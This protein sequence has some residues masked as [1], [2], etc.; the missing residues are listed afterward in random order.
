[1]AVRNPELRFKM[2]QI[3]QY[4]PWSSLLLVEDDP[5]TRKNYCSVILKNFPGIELYTAENGKIG[6][7]LY[8]E[9]TPQIVVTDVNLPVI[10]GIQMA[11]EIKSSYPETV[12][13]AI[14]GHNDARHL[15]SAIEIGINNYLIKPVDF[16]KFLSLIGKC[17][18]ESNL[19]RLLKEQESEIRRLSSFPKLSPD[20]ILELDADGKVVFSNQAAE[21]IP[22]QVECCGVSN[23]FMPENLPEILRM[24]QEKNAGQSTTEIEINGRI[25]HECIHIVPEFNSTRIYATDITECKKTEKELQESEKRYHSLFENM[26]NGFAYCKM[27]FDE[28]GRPVDFVYLEVNSA[29]GRLFGLENVVGKKVTEVFPGIT[30]SHP[31]LIEIYG[32]VALTGR[33]EKF[34]FDFKQIGAWLSIS[35]YSTEKGYFVAVFDDITERKRTE[36]EIRCR[37]NRYRELSMTD[38]LTKL[39]NSR[40]FFNRLNYEV[41]RAKRYRQPLSLVLLDIDNFKGYNDTYGHFEGDKVIRVL[42]EVI[43]KNL[44]HIDMA[45][46][47]GG[48]EFTVLLPETASNNAFIV[49]ERIRENFAKTELCPV[50]ESKV[51]MT[52]SIGVGQYIPDEQ[53]PT[54]LKR[55]DEG[56]YRAKELGKNQAYKT[57]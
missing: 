38:S 17:I 33:P 28:N 55:V 21:K 12:I 52:I 9:H 16:E 48:E 3:I 43:R 14:S 50:P 32:R 40:H 22:G 57:N 35:V 19:K 45:F 24:M 47:Y 6:L 37:E 27:L 25:Y 29:F 26:L 18:N 54:F 56:M 41:D 23:P 4:N 51:H 13:I 15:L 10:D 2:E 31:K 49:A 44:R 53:V 7:D 46:R 34:D 5:V 42:A 30:E 11:R 8:R 36:D 20:P 1:M 39:Y